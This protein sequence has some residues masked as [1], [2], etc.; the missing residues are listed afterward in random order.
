MLLVLCYYHF[1]YHIIHHILPGKL[2]PQASRLFDP[3]ATY[4]YFASCIRTPDEEF[5]LHIGSPSPIWKAS[6]RTPVIGYLKFETNENNVNYEKRR[7]PHLDHRRVQV[8]RGPNFRFACVHVCLLVCLSAC[9]SAC[10]IS[11]NINKKPLAK[12]RLS[13]RLPVLLF[14]C[15]SAYPAVHLSLS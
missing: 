2:A 5:P 15:L 4:P 11:L 7:S 3:A 14:A 8:Q 10:L 1:T 6:S 9:L 13:E 12:L